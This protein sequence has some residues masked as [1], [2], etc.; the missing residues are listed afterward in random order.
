MFWFNCRFFF[1]FFLLF[2]LLIS[3]IGCRRILQAVSKWDT[4]RVN[5]HLILFR[6]FILF[7]F[8]GYFIGEH[9]I[10]CIILAQVCRLQ[11]AAPRNSIERYRGEGL[12][13]RL[14]STE[15]ILYEIQ[16]YMCIDS[17]PV[18]LPFRFECKYPC[19]LQDGCVYS[20]SISGSDTG[21]GQPEP[22]MCVTI[23]DLSTRQIENRYT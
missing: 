6:T 11:C 12:Q 3:L 8:F 23:V 4:C 7:Y 21:P 17:T 22:F 10:I 20:I 15:Y 14:H 5:I 16:K 18:L 13:L 19:R 2:R 9:Y 1:F